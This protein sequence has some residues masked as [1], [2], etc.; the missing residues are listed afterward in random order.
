MSEVRVKVIG[1]GLAG[2]EAVWRLDRAGVPADLYE[3]KPVRFSPAHRS[4]DLAELVC[5]NSLRS[6]DPHSAVGLLKEE[7]RRLGSLVMEAADAAR[8]PAGKA[9]AVDREKFARF[10]T[11]RIEGLKGVRVA[12][13]EVAVLDPAELTVLA[14]GPLTSEALSRSLAGLVG[15]EHLYFYDAIAPIVTAESV[16]LDKAFFASR[17]GPEDGEGDYLNCPLSEPE[18]DAFYQALLAAEKSPA[19]DFEDPRYFEGCLPIEVMAERGRMTLA[20]GPMKP[21]GLVDPKTGRRPYAV[22]QLRR[23]NRAGTHY[24]LVGFQTR[25]K[26]PEQDRVFRLIPGLE[27]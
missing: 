23:E 22:V 20:F 4:P 21:V 6:D 2:C 3:M 27:R 9:L 25:L 11:A 12:R 16:D 5:S 10:I 24:N 1:G 8:V 14:T 19:R 15:T 17:Y 13:A 26:R 7:M 18:Y